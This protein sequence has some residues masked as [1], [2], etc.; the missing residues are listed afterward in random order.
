MSESIGIVRLLVLIFVPL[1][2]LYGR[3]FYLNG[4][5]DKPWFLLPIFWIFPTSVIPALFMKFG[6]IKRGE[7]TTPPYDY[8]MLIPM[9]TKMIGGFIV[10]NYFDDGL[11]A[12][13]LPFIIQLV[14]TTIPHVLKSFKWCSN[15]GTLDGIKWESI[16]SNLLTKAFI[17]GVIENGV[18]DITPVVISF[19][20]FIG[21]VVT[22]IEYIPIIGPLAEHVMWC[23]CYAGAYMVLNMY[24]GRDRNA[25]CNIP[26]FGTTSDRSAAIIL[27]IISCVTSLIP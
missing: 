5:L 17:D 21:I 16:K 4:S 24:N 1:G 14:A 26:E 13:V 9:I 25:F 18:A 15:T 3:I 11:L 23:I 20:P 8:F 27:F 6:W 22:V 19:L 12:S 2:Q 7:G 10:D